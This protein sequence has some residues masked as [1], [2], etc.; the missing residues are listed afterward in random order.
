MW[1]NKLQEAYELVEV[2]NRKLRVLTRGKYWIT[3]D[4]DIGAFD[5]ESPIWGMEFQDHRRASVLGIIKILL[6][7]RRDAKGKQNKVQALRDLEFNGK[8]YQDDKY[9]ISSLIK[10]VQFWT[11][12]LELRKVI[13][14]GFIN[15]V[16]AERYVFKLGWMRVSLGDFAGS[17]N[18]IQM[19][20][21]GWDGK[22]GKCLKMIKNDSGYLIDMMSDDF[23]KS[24]TYSNVEKERVAEAVSSGQI[25]SLGKPEVN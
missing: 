17:T 1:L 3:T 20:M 4:K 12:D 19:T 5:I 15:E 21:D 7:L 18:A 9:R 11:N 16:L 2:E 25:L 22:L 13:E 14:G 23:S 24:M 8:Y 6:E 10:D